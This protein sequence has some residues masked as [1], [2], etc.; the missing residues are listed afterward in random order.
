MQNET[1]D[2]P[3]NQAS[4][5]SDAALPA[6]AA[7]SPP[8]NPQ[9]LFPRLPGE[10]PRA[11]SAF[12]AFFDLGHSRSLQA[13]ADRLGEKLDTIKKWSS[14]FRWSDRI[15]SFNTGILQQ[16]AAGEVHR[17]SEAAA[18]WA[19]RTAQHR[20]HEWE[21]AQK[22]LTAIECFLDDFSDR[23]VEKMTLAQVSR[24]FQIA[25]S[26]A[27]STL[28]GSFA[29]EPLAMAPIQIELTAALKKAYGQPPPETESG[30]PPSVG[31]HPKTT[32]PTTA[33]S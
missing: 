25:S 14:R 32:N 11:F 16:A 20:E 5:T 13:V 30:N 19:R 26:I 12:V 22:L 4:D 10:T 6:S 23:D 21:T 18:D 7:Q 2:M 28:S 8:S 9:P 15:H 29:S 17:R 31:A 33:Q 3:A 1:S 27:R 24:A